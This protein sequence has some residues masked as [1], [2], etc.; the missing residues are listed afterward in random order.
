MQAGSKDMV[1][2]RPR[3]GG[4]IHAFTAVTDCAVLDVLAPPY[5]LGDPGAG[6]AC[7][8]ACLCKPAGQ[9]AGLGC[10]ASLLRVRK[11]DGQ[12]GYLSGA[13]LVLH[14]ACRV[15][16]GMQGVPG[17]LHACHRGMVHLCSGIRGLGSSGQPHLHWSR[18]WTVCL[19]T[20]LL[21]KLLLLSTT[22]QPS[23]ET[24]FGMDSGSSGTALP[25]VKLNKCVLADHDCTYFRPRQGP[26]QEHVLLEV[27]AWL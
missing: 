14:T 24:G 17:V 12:A 18:C 16:T 2:L 6:C 13:S 21:C 20:R 15:C 4:N 11:A 25:A 27:R 1:V 19:S 9:C 5:D 10:W 26:D 7:A 8:V 3:S 22:H 23:A